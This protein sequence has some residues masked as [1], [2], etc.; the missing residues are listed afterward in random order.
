MGLTGKKVRERREIHTNFDGKTEGKRPLDK[1]G[2][3]WEDNDG[4]NGNRVWGCGLVS[5]V[6]GQSDGLL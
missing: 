6:S 4:P 5:T 3:R 1:P 2:R